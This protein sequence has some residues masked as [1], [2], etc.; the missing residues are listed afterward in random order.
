MRY[1]CFVYEDAA[2]MASRSDAYEA[3]VTQEHL[4]YDAAMQAKG[5]FVFADA[6]A[7]PPASKVVRRR[8]GRTLVT[9]GP[10][11]ET[12]EHIGGFI[13][14]E[15]ASFEEAI[16][17]A[18]GIPSARLCAIEVRPVRDLIEEMDNRRLP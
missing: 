15:A 4:D 9:D 5:Q 18:A 16:E 10:F 12:K 2:E 17:I 8:D 1:V 6:L 14:I 13:V 11:A 7:P 3:E